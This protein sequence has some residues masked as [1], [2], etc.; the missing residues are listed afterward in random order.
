MIK[1]ITGKTKLTGL[2][3]QPVAHSISPAMHNKAF[4]L[5]GLDYVYLAFDVAP[6]QLGNAV[7]FLKETGCVGYNLTMPHKRAIL[8]FL[9]ELTPAAKLAGAVNTVLLQENGTLLGHTTDGIGFWRSQTEV[10]FRHENQIATIIGTGGAATAIIVQGALDHVKKINV[11][12][13]KNNTFEEARRFIEHI[14]S[15][16]DCELCLYDLADTSQ[17]HSSINESSILI[18]AT[19]VGMEPN[20]DKSVITDASFFHKDLLVSDIIYHPRKT[21]FLQLAENQGCKTTNG[22]YMLLYQGAA[23]FKMWT[24]TDMPTEEIKSLYF[25]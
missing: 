20:T 2:L 22:L 14:N 17:L 12:K 18:N 5:N 4:E 13:R 8:P 19:N 3:G 10:G 16:T 23:S 6:K 25:Q 1:E 7:A 24:G 15:N 9:D 21:K 11:F